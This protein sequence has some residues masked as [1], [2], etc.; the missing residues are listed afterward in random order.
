MTN[1]I[2]KRLPIFSL[3]YGQ[4]I[5]LSRKPNNVGTR[6]VLLLLLYYGFGQFS[7]NLQALVRWKRGATSRPISSL[8]G[9]LVGAL[10]DFYLRVGPLPSAQAPARP[11][12]RTW[13]N[14]NWPA[15]E[16]DESGNLENR[17]IGEVNCMCLQDSCSVNTFASLLTFT[18]L[19]L[20]VL[21]SQ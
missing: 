12:F 15:E 14:G 18:L 5:R 6:W 21:C 9:R 8:G 1:H 3:S 4:I 10:A 2:A 16:M 13:V 20:S 17:D 19:V 7:K 11:I